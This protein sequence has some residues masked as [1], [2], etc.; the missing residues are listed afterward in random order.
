MKVNL[1]RHPPL[2]PGFVSFQDYVSGEKSEGKSGVIVSV[3]SSQGFLLIL[4]KARRLVFILLQTYY[5][6][7][8]L[9]IAQH[10][11]GCICISAVLANESVVIT[12]I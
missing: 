12:S 7:M 11:N 4:D 5:H 2:P 3:N 6:Y 10:R 1:P 8:L 9:L